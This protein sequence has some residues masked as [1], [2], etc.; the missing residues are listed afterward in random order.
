MK[1][2]NFR[3]LFIIL[4]TGIAF[5]TTETKAGILFDSIPNGW[6]TLAFTPPDALV[7]T[8]TTVK[9]SGKAS[10]FLQLPP[11]SLGRSA[12]MAQG[13][14]AD[15]YRNKRV[16]LTVYVKSNEVGYAFLYMR[17]DGPDTSVSFANTFGQP[18]LE[19]TEWTQYHITLDVPEES[20][21]IS[22]GAV[23]NGQGILW[24]DDYNLE[25]VDRS[26]PSDDFFSKGRL[27]SGKKDP[28]RTYHP[29]L[30]AINLGFED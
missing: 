29:N 30:T 11:M 14:A 18:V 19:T 26:V 17:V 1:Y 23:L 2:S 24:V 13:I 27:N 3:S 20:S 22:F 9:H 12:S 25:V 7:G 21:S 15:P 16:R 4:F 10:G 5:M 8:D 6:R 28:K